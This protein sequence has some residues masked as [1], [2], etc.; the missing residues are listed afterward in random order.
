M[1]NSYLDH[2]LYEKA[3]NGTQTAFFLVEVVAPYEFRFLRTNL[4]HQT[5][6]GISQEQIQNQTPQ[7]LLGK[8]LGNQVVINFQKCVDT[9]KN[10]TYE[11]TL[12]LP[13]GVRIWTTTL[14]P[15]I[16][17]EITRFI[18]GSS[19]DITERVENEEKRIAS[20]KLLLKIINTIPMRIFWK[21]KDL[22]YL[23]CNSHF[24][25]DSGWGSPEAL[26]GKNDYDMSWKSLAED[27]R[28]DDLDVMIQEEE[29][30]NYIEK[31]INA[32]G[33][34]RFVRTSKI[35]LYDQNNEV[36]GM[37]GAFE[38]ITDTLNLEE[39]LKESEQRYEELASISKAVVFELDRNGIYTYVSPSVEPILGYKPAEL[40][41]KYYFYDITSPENRQSLMDY[42]KKILKE[43]SRVSDYEH[44]LQRKDQREVWVT[45][46]GFCLL[47]KNG[48]TKS[49]RGMDIDITH[50]KT[51]EEKIRYLSFHD[52]LT[53]LYNRH[54]F[55]AEIQRLDTYRNWPLT[56]M[57][58]DANG[59]KLI[60]D[61]FGH[62]AGDELLIK[63]AEAL[64]ESIRSD[65]IISR[66]GGDEYVLLLPGTCEEEAEKMVERIQQNTDRKKI[67]NLP[68]SFSYGYYTKWSEKLTVEDTLKLAETKMYKQKND[69]KRSLRKKMIQRILEELFHTVPEEKCHGEKVAAL[70][71]EIGKVL[72]FEKRKLEKLRLAGYYHDIGKIAI[73]PAILQNGFRLTMDQREEIQ[74]HAEAGYVILS[75]SSDYLNISEDV[76]QH[77]EQ[78]NGNGYPAGLSGDQINLNAQI[79][80]IANY[81]DS[82]SRNRPH[83]DA[84]SQEVVLEQIQQQRGKRFNPRLVDAFMKA[85]SS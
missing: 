43:G 37:L 36:F 69:A 22:K 31:V 65:D 20:E 8:E 58:V 76:L 33:E 54:F 80:S 32:D 19:T 55:E 52:Q 67:K 15:I 71:F 45:T 59:L 74:R 16:Q 75:S 63:M 53:G 79:I 66:I 26:I 21:D 49:F 2:E 5:K 82:M 56:I 50:I 73:D 29:K 47:D 40:I 60:N 85:I 46:N 6:T 68:L 3:F 7:S 11:E 84:L 27:Y 41:G 61:A 35:P 51:A 77:H 17:K 78:Y 42:G 39:A 14:T 10:I 23:G 9:G 64:K 25:K 48:R 57:M 1:N 30:I 83:R 62:Q 24:A 13:G 12:D 18:V 81:Y 4:A 38:D 44:K 72:G 28:K 34:R 70:C